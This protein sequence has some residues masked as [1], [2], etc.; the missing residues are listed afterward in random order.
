MDVV[1]RLVNRSK[2]D[3]KRFYIGCKTE[4][5]VVD[6]GGVSTMVN[7][8][9]N[10]PYYSSSQSPEMARDFELGN[11]FEV[12]I[13]EVVVGK[14]LYEVECSYIEKFDAVNSDEYYNMSNFLVKNVNINSIANSFGESI[15]EVAYRNSS[16]S[17]RDA[18]AIKMG[19]ENFGFLYLHIA[20]RYASGE[21]MA[22][23]SKSL[24]RQRH[25]CGNT[26]KGVD[27]E[28]C[29]FEI[30]NSSA[31]V[32]SLR[33]LVSKGCTFYKASEILGL[34]LPSARIILG[35]FLND[36]S[37]L[38]SQRLG[39]SRD[40]LGDKILTLILSGKDLNEVARDLNMIKKTVERY[41]IQAVRYRLN[42][43]DVR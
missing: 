2:V 8:R 30:L 35:N 22:K 19:F 14:D 40:E 34:E 41:F 37:Y 36:K 12:E 7:V 10:K 42:T 20:K 18:G 5:K 39:L 24:G 4:C 17:K 11:V 9:N 1:Y 13:L 6:I 27:V 23:I 26:F 32:D 29:D 28:K 31:Y 33:D 15:K 21:S 3:G 43:S 25:F 38:A 16:L